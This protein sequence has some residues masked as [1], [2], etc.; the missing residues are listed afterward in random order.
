MAWYSPP[1]A[2][3]DV[4][5]ELGVHAT[6]PTAETASSSPP[7]TTKFASELFKKELNEAM[8]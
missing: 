3:N 6:A 5:A 1:T 7:S 8:S 4:G 2:E